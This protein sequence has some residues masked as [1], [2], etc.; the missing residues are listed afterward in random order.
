MSIITIQRRQNIFRRSIN[1]AWING[2]TETDTFKIDEQRLR[3]RDLG[4]GYVGHFSLGHGITATWPD[5]T[6][7][8]A[9]PGNRGVGN[10]PPECFPPCGRLNALLRGL[11]P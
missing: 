5:G 11:A 7:E 4:Q 8:H 1:G 3:P 9:Y 2:H 10:Y 6:V